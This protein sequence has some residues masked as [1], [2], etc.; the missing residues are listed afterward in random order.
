MLTT[1]QRKQ[2]HYEIWT[3]CGRNPE[4]LKSDWPGLNNYD[5]AD[6]YD[7]STCFACVE[8]RELRN[9]FPY[10]GNFCHYCPID[11]GRINDKFCYTTFCYTTDTLFDLYNVSYSLYKSYIDDDI[12]EEQ[13]QKILFKRSIIAFIIANKWR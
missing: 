1:E 10:D 12:H 13:I 2:A 4:K 9:Y 5:Q 8:A 11:W 6:Y 7:V 3:W